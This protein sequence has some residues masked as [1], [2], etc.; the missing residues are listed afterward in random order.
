MMIHAASCSWSDGRAAGDLMDVAVLIGGRSPEHDISVASALQVLQ[1]LDRERWTPWP[2]LLDREGYWRCARRP[3]A[4]GQ[5]WEPAGPTDD[6]RVMRPGAAMDWLLDEACVDLF[7]PVL[8]GPCGEDGTV[9]G[10]L[11]LYDVP[12]VGSGCAASAVAM[13]KIRTRQALTAGGVSLAPAYVPTDPTSTDAEAE[14][15]SL[16][17][18]VGVPAFAKVDASGST[19]GV[20]RVADEADLREFLE[21]YA[22][23]C[24]RWFAEGAV[25]GEEITV[26]VLGNTGDHVEALPAV[27]IYP[28]DDD[29]F[30]HDAKYR[31]GATEELVPPRGLSAEQIEEVQRLAV[32]CHELLVCDGMS[33]TDMIYT[34]VGPVVLETNT[35]PGLTSNS[36]LP[37]S[38]AAAGIEFPALLDRLLDLALRRGRAPAHL[39]ELPSQQGREA[40][41][42]S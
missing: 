18:A 1:N 24:R 29:W 16:S 34:D 30:T 10:M 42:Q 19:V 7:F 38:A 23:N 21:R 12:F 17:A 5:A 41:A 35:I 9:Q 13:D 33:R 22:G 25:S 27:G 14:Y 37:R 28:V 4:D 31:P 6:E 20:R 26:P 39:A 40:P 8:H 2:V 11:E 32:R 3:L 36:L 15:R